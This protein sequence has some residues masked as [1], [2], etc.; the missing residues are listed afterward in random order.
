LSADRLR[1]L[2]YQPSATESLLNLASLAALR[3]NMGTKRPPFVGLIGCTGTGKSTLFNSFAGRDL[4]ATGW[5]AHNTRGPVFLVHSSFLAALN[6]VEHRLG[7]LLLPSLKR[8]V[9]SADNGPFAA[10]SPDAVNLISMD[11]HGQL[12]PILIDLPDINTTLAGEENLIALN[13]QPWL[14]TV[15]FMVDDETVYHRDYE[16]PV[17]LAGELQQICLCVLNNRGKDRVDLDHPDLQKAKEFFRVETIHV[18][19]E[20]KDQTR[21][22]KEPPFLQLKEALYAAAQRS[23]D[24]PVLRKTAVYAREIIEE[25]RKRQSALDCIERDVSAAINEILSRE[26]PI[27]LEKI[28]HDDVLA[29]LQHI[30]L[31]RFAMSN[32]Y[33]FLKRVAKTGSLKRSFRVAF[34]D[35]RGEILSHMLHLDP[36]KLTREV[37]QRLSSHIEIIANRIRRNK[38]VESILSKAP[39]LRLG[40]IFREEDSFSQSMQSIVEAFERACREMIASDTIASSVKN[41]PFV[42]VALL[43]A[44]IADVLAVPGFGSWLL[45]PSALR[46]LPLGQFASAKRRFQQEVHETIRR[47]LV[48]TTRSIRGF[49]SRIV[50]ENS[51]PLLRALITCAEYTDHDH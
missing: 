49:R 27:P 3:R 16:G 34:G 15:V 50:L 18:L 1:G 4:S 40:Y 21:F 12:A 46:Y 41:D 42:A 25:N 47:E 13:L 28:L 17:T 9:L 45:V 8:E 35:K 7:P 30:G 19:P 20:I 39:E 6:E 23:P 26:P 36:K 33:Q 11:N 43:V 24:P 32:I 44:L 37:S 22:E 10:G 29:V 48:R 51:A 2:S 31:K 14:D 5:R 38:Q